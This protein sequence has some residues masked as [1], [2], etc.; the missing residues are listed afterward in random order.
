VNPDLSTYEEKWVLRIDRKN[1]YEFQITNGTTDYTD[2]H[3]LN[4]KKCFEEI[5]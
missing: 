5:I 2:F 4:D 1:N 3:G